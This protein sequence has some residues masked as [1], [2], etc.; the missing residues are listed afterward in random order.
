MQNS[1]IIFIAFLFIAIW[2]AF[3][4]RWWIKA[5]LSGVRVSGSQVLFMRFRGSNVSLIINSL[6]KAAKG[7]VLLDINTL[8]AAHLSGEQVDRLVE[9]LIAAKKDGKNLSV[10]EAMKN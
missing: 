2:F 5:L 8:E 10:A 9:K 1:T 4:G 6:I 3:I 7:G